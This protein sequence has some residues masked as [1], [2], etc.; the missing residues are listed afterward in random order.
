MTGD[1]MGFGLSAK[2]RR[3]STPPPYC[4]FECVCVWQGKYISHI[5]RINLIEDRTRI[6][7]Y[8]LS[9]NETESVC[10][11]HETRNSVN[12]WWKCKWV[13]NDNLYRE[14]FAKA[15]AEWMDTVQSV[16]EVLSHTRSGTF[17]RGV[18]WLTGFCVGGTGWWIKIIFIKR[19]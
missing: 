3:S 1:G 13:D 14:A 4:Y 18:G 10:A 6:K 12:G 11:N 5:H 16:D 2:L 8:L 19:R 7:M 15:P 17:R 9:P